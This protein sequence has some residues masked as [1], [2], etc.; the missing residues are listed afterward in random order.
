[1]GSLRSFAGVGVLCAMIALGAC[2]VVPTSGPA[3]SDVRG[4]QPDGESIPY[5]LVRVTPRV[6]DILA[7]HTP[8]LSTAFKDRRGP[9]Q[10]RLGIGDIVGVQLFEAGAG[11]LFI[12]LEAG[13]RA[14][15]FINLNNQAVDNNGNISIPYGGTIRAQGRTPVEVQKAIVDALKDRALD[16]QALV[17]LVE[18]RAS[19]ISVLGDGVGSVRFPASASGERILDAITRAGLRPTPASDLWVMLERDR[20]REIIPFGALVYEPV[21]N[22]YVRPNDTIFVYR[23]PQTFLAFGASGRQGQL[24]FETWRISLAEAAAKAGGLNDSQADP[25]SIF[26]YRGETREVATLL[27][28]DCTPF[29][30]PIIPV[31]YNLNLRDPAGYFLASK[32]EM[33]NKDVIYISNASSVDSSKFL[34]YLRL[35][36]AT[37]SDPVVAATNVYILRNTI[38]T[39]TSAI[40]VSGSTPII[41][42][43]PT[44]VITGR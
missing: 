1:V 32:F 16:P 24:P 19:S 2:T 5:A 7:T 31:I 9:T 37:A 17:T 42:T 3:S 12:P 40:A 14:G 4:G 41:Q 18:Q 30:G 35:L 27:G 25:A 8:K 34:T 33:H 13:V 38:Q 26:L 20:R 36:I 43:G 22:I 39:P 29:A 15:N 21:N 10:I 11:G 28:I 6:L 23:D 44:S